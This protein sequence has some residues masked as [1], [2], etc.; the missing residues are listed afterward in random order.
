MHTFVYPFKDTYINN[1]KDFANKN[2]G[3]DEI[4]ELFALNYGSKIEYPSSNWRA[5]PE[6]SSSYGNEGWFAYDDSYFYVYSNGA[7]R[8]FAI[9]QAY[10]T[11]P[12]PMDRFSGRLS[13][14]TDDPYIGLYVSGSATNITGSISG[15]YYFTS[16]VYASGSFTTGSLNGNIYISTS[17]SSLYVNG[18]Q[19][20]DSPLTSS[21]SGNA[22]F[23]NLNGIIFGKSYTGTG[24]LCINSGSFSGSIS[25]SDFR[26]KL[27]VNTVSQSAIPCYVDVQNFS[28]EFYGDYTGSFNAPEPVSY[29]ITPEISRILLQFNLNNISSSIAKNEIS[30]SNIKFTLNLTACGQRNLPLGYTIY[31]YPLSQSW[32][33][34][35]GRYVDGG[36]QNGVS[37]KYK[38]YNDGEKW[39]KPMTG[40]YVQ[41]DYFL[42]S[43]NSSYS[44]QNGGGTWY[45][46]APSTYSNKNHWICSSSAFY[47]LSGSN[48]ICS[49]SFIFGELGDL[50]IDITKIVR[51]WLCGCIPNNGL[52]LMTSLETEVPEI[53]R[54]NGLLQFFS[55]ETN[56][57]YSPYVDMAWDDSVYNTGNLSPVTGSQ[58]NLITLNLLK[59]SYKAGSVPK[60]FVFARD[61]Y[62]LKQFNKAYQQPSMVT[63]KYL[64][65]SS[66]YMIKDA[67]SEQVFVDFN[68]YS[69]L[70]CDPIKG[71]YFQFDTTSLPQERYF[72]IFI[73]AEYPDGTVD[74][75]DT[76]KI[77]KITR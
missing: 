46:D 48:L 59:D 75:V 39:C 17:F 9:A 66:Y 30:S 77:F 26:G 15:S 45:Y 58:E 32:D 1:S 69:K 29:L 31:A 4:L 40:S 6:N 25:G 18:N 27:I 19:Y 57:I 36:S 14:V 65:T 76:Q 44:F 50:K 62:F 49:Q 60:V 3:V 56:T 47:P 43:S 21:L 11:T 2:F 54:T 13:N 64:P 23:E 55:K 70:S 73:K 35:N 71:N 41:K 52:I 12:T 20:T 38:N 7:W 16:N 72:K 42:T 63:P 53:G 28:G 74:V 22:N 67:E 33:N 8:R 10:I 51:S 5:V 68:E 61:R 34:G 37:W 24:T